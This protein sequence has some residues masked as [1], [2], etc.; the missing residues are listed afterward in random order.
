MG[1][2]TTPAI[3][4]IAETVF[5]ESFDNTSLMTQSAPFGVAGTQASPDYLGLV[6]GVAS[7]FGSDTA[8]ARIKSYSGKCCQCA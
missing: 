3:T 1:P 5:F 2:S 4:R 8:P 6:G 7:N